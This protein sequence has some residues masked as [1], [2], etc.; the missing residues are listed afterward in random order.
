MPDLTFFCLILLHDASNK[1]SYFK[2]NLE[3]KSLCRHILKHI[4]C[5]ICYW[6]SD[7]EEKNCFELKNLSSYFKEKEKWLKVNYSEKSQLIGFY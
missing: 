7:F 5:N 3:K 1:Y 4:F 2:D 6:A